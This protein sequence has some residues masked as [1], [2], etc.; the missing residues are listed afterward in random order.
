MEDMAQREMKRKH[1]EDLNRSRR[2]K[3]KKQVVVRKVNFA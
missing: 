2:E 3:Q 1:D